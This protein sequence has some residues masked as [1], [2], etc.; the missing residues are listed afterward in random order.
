[1]KPLPWSRCGSNLGTQSN[2]GSTAAG[3]AVT[4]TARNGAH[5]SALR[6]EKK[7]HLQLRLIGIDIS[8]EILHSFA[9]CFEQRNIS[10]RI[11]SPGKSRQ[12]EFV[13]ACA[14][15][16]NGE[17]IAR[18]KSIPPFADD[19]GLTFGI[20]SEQKMLTFPDLSVNVLLDDC[21]E[22]TIR[23]AI[24]K[25]APLLGRPMTPHDRIP[26]V[27]RMNLDTE[28]VS[29]NGLTLNVG[30][31]GMAVRLRRAMDLP[32]RVRITCSL[33]GANPISLDATP[34]WHSGRT[35]GLQYV[36]APPDVL[37]KWLGTYSARLSVTP[38]MTHR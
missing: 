15:A 37:K 18:L 17:A 31:G 14:V 22:S 29:L 36:S 5:P 20:G 13:S 9:S 33:P 7:D 10:V 12:Q 38:V 21:T 32:Q 19:R 26:I 34:R 23:A 3:T 35:V 28:S 16:I 27:T 2:G 25:T 4:Q 6:P 11:D 8:S 1:M 24:D 30:H